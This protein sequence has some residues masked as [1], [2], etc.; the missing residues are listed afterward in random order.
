MPGD[1]LSTSEE[2]LPGDGTFEE[3]GI[4][5]ASRIGVYIVDE[6]HRR[7]KVK[8]ITSVPVILQ[9]GDTVLAEVRS[10]RSSMV[11]VDV[12]HVVGKNR[13][14]SGDTDG[15]IHASEISRSYVKDA[16]TEYKTGDILRARVFQTKP[17]IQL[18]TKDKDLGAIKALC[19]KCRHLLVKKDNIL[20]CSN[21]SNRERRKI[22]LDYGNIDLDKL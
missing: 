4:I 20:E 7:A 16:S 14:V 2:L 1:Q 15:T 10:V 6:K 11:V 3:D 22:A 8:P 18:T 9:K 21:C 5:R 17:S 13:T 12:F 19:V